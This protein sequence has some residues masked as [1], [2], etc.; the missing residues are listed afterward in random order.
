M[1]IIST[2]SVKIKEYRH[3]FKESLQIYRS[4]V[5]FFIDVCLKEWTFISVLKGLKMQQSYVESLTV[6][7]KDR[8][9]VS[10]N[11]NAKFYKMPCYLR[12]AAI[13]EAV[14][15]VSSYKSNL[16]NW[17]GSDP[18]T[19]GEKPSHPKAG[20]CYPALYKVNM[21]VRVDDYTAK[22]KVF[23]NNTWDWITIQLR[24]SDVDY[25]THHCNRMEECAPTLQKRGKVWYLDF[26]FK[27]KCKL[28]TTPIKEQTIVA[29]DLGINSSATCSVLNSGGAVLGRHFLKFPKEYDSLNRKI[30]HIKYAQRHGSRSTPR[31]W[32]FA[33]GVN[34]DIAVKTADFIIKVAILYDADVIVF[35][36]L[37]FG[38]KKRGSKK[39]RLAL[40]KARYVQQMVE[41]KAHV[42][43]I[44][45]S[46]INACGTSKLAFDGSGTVLRGNKSTKTG[47]NY[48]LCEFQNGK[49]YNC[50]LSASYNIGARYFVREILKSL[51]ATERQRIEAKVPG[52]AKRS[53]C[54]LSTLIS[55]NGELGSAELSIAV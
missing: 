45:I 24:K 8:P 51:P 32:A 22:I 20:Y 42:N 9:K 40:W 17:E 39:Q 43:G 52:C 14:G 47:N 25:I 4:A 31:L 46:H 50:D 48:S 2:Y 33:K 7:T 37:D 12:R 27:E 26:P 54:T 3:I 21:F 38:K 19:R 23:R 29:V 44:R 35:E 36:H 41:H 13:S 49:I 16:S 28:K 34:N 18:R 10:H 15:R 5:D 30:G 1:D 11:F 53:I 6:P 55:L